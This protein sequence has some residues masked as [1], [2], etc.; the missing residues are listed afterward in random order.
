MEEIEN[1]EKILIVDDSFSNRFLLETILEDYLTSTAG[2]GNEMWQILENDIP[3]LILLDVMMPFEDGFEI[4]K[5]L[6][7][8]TKYCDIPIIFVTAKSTGKDVE[9]GFKLGGY[10][11]IKKPIDELDLRARVKSA[12]TKKRYEK[13]LKQQSIT[14]ELT[15]INNRRFFFENAANLINYCNRYEKQFAIGIVDID[16][17]KTVNDNYGHLVGDKILQAFAQSLKKMIRKYDLIARYGGEEF[18]FMLLDCDRFNA[19]Q[20]LIRF[21]N[22]LNENPFQINNNLFNLTFSCGISDVLDVS[23]IHISAIDEFIKIAD[24]RLYEAKNSGRNKIIINNF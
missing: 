3:S 18:I 21:K 14:D 1:K 19:K 23:D 12:L 10:D 9:E 16:F 8:D 13:Q 15:G 17:F 11:Y 6:S 22:S 20:I 24:K 5:K 2:N 4:A 7:N